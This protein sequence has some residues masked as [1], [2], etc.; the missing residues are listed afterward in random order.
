MRPFHRFR[1]WPMTHMLVC[2][3]LT[4]TLIININSTKSAKIQSSNQNTQA[5]SIHVHTTNHSTLLKRC[6]VTEHR[7]ENG[8][9]RNFQPDLE[10]AMTQQEHLQE[11]IERLEHTND[12]VA[13]Y[14]KVPYKSSQNFD[15]RT[16]RSLLRRID[17]QE[18][19]LE[20]AD[21]EMSYLFKKH[22]QALSN[23]YN[24]HLQ[25]IQV[26]LEYSTKNDG[27]FRNAV[28]ES[29]TNPYYRNT[30][31]SWIL[32]SVELLPMF[33]ARLGVKDEDFS[34]LAKLTSSDP[35]YSVSECAKILRNIGSRGSGF[36]SNYQ[37]ESAIEEV[38]L[39][40]FWDDNENGYWKQWG[41]KD[42]FEK[43][44]DSSKEISCDD[45]TRLE[46]LH[47]SFV[48]RN[49]NYETFQEVKMHW[50][51]AIS[52]VQLGEDDELQ[53]FILSQKAENQK[54]D[55][56]EHRTLTVLKD[57]QELTSHLQKNIENLEKILKSKRIRGTIFEK[58]HE[59]LCKYFHKQIIDIEQSLIQMWE[60]KC[61]FASVLEPILP[62]NGPERQLIY[63]DVTVH[64][65]LTADNFFA[66]TLLPRELNILKH[67]KDFK[68]VPAEHILEDI[69]LKPFLPVPS[70]EV[71][72]RDFT[73]LFKSEGMKKIEIE[74]K[75]TGNI[76]KYKRLREKLQMN[77]KLYNDSPVYKKYGAYGT[78]LLK[79]AYTRISS[80]FTKH[81]TE[82]KKDIL[83]LMWASEVYPDVNSRGEVSSK[84]SSVNSLDETPYTLK[85]NELLDQY[86]KMFKY[87][88]DDEAI[89]WLLLWL[90]EE[91]NEVKKEGESSKFTR[92]TEID[93]KMLAELECSTYT[94]VEIYILYKFVEEHI[95]MTFEGAVMK[96]LSV[97]DNS[98]FE[99]K[100]LDKIST[101]VWKR[102]P[103]T[104]K[105]KQLALKIYQKTQMHH[106]KLWISDE[107]FM[108][109]K[110]YIHGDMKY[111]IDDKEFEVEA[112]SKHFLKRLTSVY[113]DHFQ[114][115]SQTDA[116][117]AEIL[118]HVKKNK[119]RILKRNDC[120]NNTLWFYQHRIE[121]KISSAKKMKEAM[122]E[123][124]KD[125][126][127]RVNSFSILNEYIM[128]QGASNGFRKRVRTARESYRDSDTDAKRLVSRVTSVQLSD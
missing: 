61:R 41:L 47:V 6:V 92:D 103:L 17:R 100:L 126:I 35:R 42:L 75:R 48:L 7:I 44:Y 80:E 106:G 13:I 116:K 56:F 125:V 65:P 84:P 70:P 107:T 22:Q 4:T 98:L 24:E 45:K 20:Q 60:R 32:K 49:I 46:T 68:F 104:E 30:E 113:P 118:T 38:F 115:I 28:S 123:E 110:P 39:Q 58:D 124:T 51:S 36:F 102:I 112:L 27:R 111:I 26:L 29:E 37:H 54:I 14:D 23:I 97:R 8:F 82:K 95:P 91:V 10:M 94:P 127:N 62:Y 15:V 90:G 108:K 99:H 9:M 64:S 57:R 55:E 78:F 77:P 86:H 74:E 34:Y 105:E 31:L 79:E 33:E 25:N 122:E 66:M 76:H 40:A 89:L 19:S 1:I 2:I 85:D 12:M 128:K 71:I 53:L 83:N 43:I 117:N 59:F 11:T 50:Y 69:D 81:W 121:K 109:E 93:S 114:S 21:Q 3:F 5:P 72:I 16:V 96:F 120:I 67:T 18:D 63:R 52:D 88:T 73:G 87:I 119:G 101:A